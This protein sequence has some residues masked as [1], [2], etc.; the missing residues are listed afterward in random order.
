M[1]P[2]SVRYR[3]ESLVNLP[4]INIQKE[5]YIENN[6]EKD[7]YITTAERKMNLNSATNHCIFLL[8]TVSLLARS[9]VFVKIQAKNPY[10][11]DDLNF[12]LEQE[13]I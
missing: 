3:N 13:E 12:V 4:L 5:L 2:V 6:S 11:L 10:S 7:V 9:C 1:L 8:Y